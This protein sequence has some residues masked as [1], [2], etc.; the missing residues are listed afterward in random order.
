MACQNITA[1]LG[2]GGTVTVFPA[3]V[4]AGSA[5]N[6]GLASLTLNGQPSVT[7]T[8]ANTGP[9]NVT[10]IATDVNG[11][12]DSCIAV[13]TVQDTVF[14]T[15]LCNNINVFLDAGGN[16]SIVPGDVDGGSS[17]NCAISSITINGVAIINYTCAD[18]GPNNVT[19]AVTDASGNTSTCN[20][21]VTVQDTTSP[22]I[23]CN[24]I[25]VQLGAATGTVNVVP[26]DVLSPASADACGIA[27]ETING[28]ASVTYT[29][30]NVGPNN[31]TLVVSDNNGNNS[32]CNAVVTVED[33]T[34]PVLTCNNI[35]VTLDAAGNA[36]VVPS[37]VGTANDN[38]GVASF[39]INGQP[40][41]TFTCANAGPNVVT[42]HATDVNGNLD[43]CSATVTVQDLTP[44]SA[45]CQN[46][47]AYLDATGSVTV[48]PTDVDGGST[49]NCTIVTYTVNNQP[50]VTFNCS[51]TASPQN[52]TTQK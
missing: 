12:V 32:T 21:V 11:N 14:P 5:D 10:L 23:N 50:S 4:D 2:A 27:S 7:F 15:A 20:S 31:V 48:F 46:Y 1:Q 34:N 25:T 36:T 6:C 26:G 43:S 8:C 47:N 38:C 35:S 52:Y 39:T 37:D 45:I 9:N 49:D 30:A 44:P 18:V 13:V 29:C 17:D 28:A 16:A 3:D 19:L 22:V 40:S 41:V 51:N 33:A 24:N 42:L